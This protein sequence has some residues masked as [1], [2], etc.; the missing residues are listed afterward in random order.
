MR[1]ETARMKPIWFHPMSYTELREDSRSANPSIRL[2][3]IR[4]HST[5]NAGM[6]YAMIRTRC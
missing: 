4:H 1:L 6:T 3:F 2:V 5:E